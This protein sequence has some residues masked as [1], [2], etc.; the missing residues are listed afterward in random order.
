MWAILLAAGGDLFGALRVTG[1]AVNLYRNHV[2]T[3]P[4]VLPQLHAVLGLQ[5]DLLQALKREE[6]AEQIRR[7]LRANPLPPDSRH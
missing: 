7:W 5:A 4:A 6:E 3:L 1:E 2:G